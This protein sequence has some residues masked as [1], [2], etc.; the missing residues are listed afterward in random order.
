[1]KEEAINPNPPASYRRILKAT[2]VLGATQVLTILSGVARTKVAALVL[3]PSGIGM[4]GLFSSSL[5]IFKAAGGLGLPYSS[6]RE[7]SRTNASGDSLSTERTISILKRWLLLTAVAG[8]LAMIVLSP[9]LSRKT[10]GTDDY[11]FSFVFLS[12]A[13]FFSTLAAGGSSILQG[14]GRLNLLA[15]AG[16]ISSLL[17]VATTVPLYYFLGKDGIVPS[18]VLSAFL[19]YAVAWFYTR[20]VKTGKV[21]LKTATREGLPMVRLGIVLMISSLVNMLVAYLLRIY[22]GASGGL[23]EVGFLQAGM[24]ITE[25]YLGIIFT[26]M[27]ADFYPRL[28]AVSDDNKKM[29]S[30]INEQAE[31]GLLIVG[32]VVIVFLSFLPFFIRLLYE[33]RFLVVESFLVWA[34]AGNLLKIASVTIALTLIAKGRSRLFI[35]VAISS[36]FIF[37]LISCLGYH[38]GGIAGM[39]MAYL[40]NY[41]IHLI[42]ILVICS[43][44]FR[45]SYRAPFWKIFSITIFFTSAV[46]LARTVPSE[47]L[48]Y[49]LC[50]L[51]IV[52][53][54]FY[55][56]YELGRRLGWRSLIKNR[57]TSK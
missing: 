8:S 34:L 51:C 14:L 47:G 11:T 27:N 45:L 36:Q 53:S 56:L 57:L 28:S 23:E 15:K 1:M 41:A 37:L 16:A 54:A 7:I 42:L 52:L 22:V 12:L 4:I 31:T 50:S 44:M 39:G 2:S 19:L 13:V 55:S 25:S 46:L 29:G 17:S 35:T 49:L 20:K 38:L 26:S 33:G 5:E 30:L 32:P 18:F 9:Y 3:G 21:S 48:G 10:F 43:S 24:T 40:V 6:I